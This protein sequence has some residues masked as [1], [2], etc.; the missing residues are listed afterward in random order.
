MAR[1]LDCNT[2]FQ[3]QCLTPGT[4]Q[5]RVGTGRPTATDKTGRTVEDVTYES[6]VKEVQSRTPQDFERIGQQIRTNHGPPLRP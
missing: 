4:N 2:A 3:V 5:L 6:L 1:Q